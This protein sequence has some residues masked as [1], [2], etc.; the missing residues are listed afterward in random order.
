VLVRS[1]VSGYVLD[2]AQES[3]TIVTPG[4]RIMLVGDVTDI[5]VMLEMLSE[6]AVKAKP[7]MDALIEG[8]GGMP[9]HGRVRLV[10]PFSYTKISALGIEEQRVHVL[11]DFTDPREKWQAM[12]HGYRVT[13]RIITWVGHDVLKLPMGALFR[14]GSRWAVYTIEDGVARRRY[15][16]LGHINEAEAE[17]LSGVTTG[18]K[19]ILHPSDRIAEG[20]PVRVR[21]G[22]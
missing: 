8:W 14:D 2:V 4:Q 17:V 10:E 1:P 21:T 19:V 16:E 5:E 22:S 6:D 13:G 18:A 11:I 3:E 7:G 9:L 12:G 15:V 20:V